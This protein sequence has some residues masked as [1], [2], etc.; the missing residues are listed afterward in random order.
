MMRRMKRSMCGSS[1][2]WGASRTSGST[3]MHRVG[4][5][6]VL[7]CHDEQLCCSWLPGLTSAEVQPAGHRLACITMQCWAMP[8]FSLS[9]AEAAG[10]G[11]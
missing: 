7:R 9:Q 8:P 2:R 3:A 11:A 10:L 5:G 4:W 6:V 1:R